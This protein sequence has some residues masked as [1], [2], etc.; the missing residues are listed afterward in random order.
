MNILYICNKGG[1]YSQMLRLK[2]VMSKFKS[3]IVSDKKDASKDWQGFGEAIYMDAY[4]VKKHRLYHFFK[5]LW[6]CLR[7]C[8]KYKPKYIVTTGAGLAVPMFLVGRLMG[9]KLIFIESRAR[10]Y[11]KSASGKLLGKL[12]HKVIVQWPEMLDV[13]GEKASYYGT[14]V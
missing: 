10:V 7:I 8:Q 13:Y 2:D 12:A 1:H 3:Y 9:K 14:L 11:T 5:N 4:N 6:Q